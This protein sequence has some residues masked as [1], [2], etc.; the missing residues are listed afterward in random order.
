MIVVD[1]RLVESI[2]GG[3]IRLATRETEPMEI[4][5]S[6]MGCGIVK[7]LGRKA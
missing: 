1:I 3:R 5:S 6:V 2:G 4:G 7:E